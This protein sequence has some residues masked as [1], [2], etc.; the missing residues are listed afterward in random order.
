M[1]LKLTNSKL[2]ENMG[3]F[4]FE[5]YIF[6]EFKELID[7]MKTQHL[8]DEYLQ[9]KKNESKLIFTKFQNIS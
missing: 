9:K 6:F 5:K 7:E 2:A 4:T 1:V 3:D 8:N